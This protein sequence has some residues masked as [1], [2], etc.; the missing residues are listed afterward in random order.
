MKIYRYS[1]IFF[2]FLA[3]SGCATAK[4]GNSTASAVNRLAPASAACLDGV[5]H[6]VIEVGPA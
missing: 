1:I 3:L 4:P 6:A 2:V 5:I